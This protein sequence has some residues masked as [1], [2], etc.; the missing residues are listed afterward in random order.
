MGYN[1]FAYTFFVYA[2]FGF[3]AHVHF[4]KDPTHRFINDIPDQLQH[5]FL[6]ITAPQCT[7]GVIF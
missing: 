6:R 2:I 7:C 4:S 3:K 5:L 1:A